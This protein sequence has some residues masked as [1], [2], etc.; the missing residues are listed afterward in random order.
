VKSAEIGRLNWFTEVKV[1]L[2]AQSIEIIT[3]DGLLPMV[4][5]LG[6]ILF[7]LPYSSHRYTEEIDLLL[8]HHNSHDPVQQARV[9]STSSV[10]SIEAGMRERVRAE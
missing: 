6:D 5:I 9:S 8:L 4:E 3:V 7:T 10:Y 2:R 1:T